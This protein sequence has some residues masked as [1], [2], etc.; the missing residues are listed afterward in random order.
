MR[1][2]SNST[3]V[4]LP[5]SKSLYI[6]YL[7]AIYQKEQQL[8]SVGEN[9]AN[10]V[11]I[12]AKNLRLVHNAIDLTNIVCVDVEDCGAAFR[13]FLPLLATRPGRWLLTGTNRI[14][15]RPIMPLVKSLQEIGADISPNEKGIFI[16]GKPL[17]DKRMTIDCTQSSQFASALLLSSRQL[18]LEELEITPTSPPSQSYITMTKMVMEDVERNLFSQKS[19]EADWSAALFWYGCA[20]LCP[21]LT[22]YLPNLKDES[23]QGDRRVATWFEKLGVSS[24]FDNEGVLVAKN[25]P[26][27]AESEFLFDL[28]DNPDAAPL[29]SVL[30]VCTGRPFFLQG[31]ENLNHKESRR[32][33]VIAEELANYAVID[34]AEAEGYL[35]I[36]P[37]TFPR[38]KQLKFK[39]HNDHRIIMA[40]SLFSLYN[41]IEF[42]ETAS[43]KKSYP[44]FFN[45]L[46][47][48]V[49]SVGT[50]DDVQ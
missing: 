9:E 13:F 23:L 35:K 15:A 42:D 24:R 5:L 14:L 1:D 17:H 49:Q 50:A 41:Q 10:D 32:S 39:S 27:S 28:R 25:L 45:D 6:R 29:L 38:G 43:I 47:L 48:V 12:V 20:A 18:G 11:Q 31:I 3:T 2:N 22:I 30:S 46:S 4:R 34:Y 33:D 26:E 8:L 19:I 37:H 40:F 44:A 21:N 36:I 16:T 7:I